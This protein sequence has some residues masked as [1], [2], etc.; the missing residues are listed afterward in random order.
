MPVGFDAATWTCDAAPGSSCGAPSGTGSIDQLV[1][2]GA[3]ST[4]TYIV[5]GTISPAATG[6]LANTATVSPGAGTTD[7]DPTN[8]SATDVDNLTPQANLEIVKTDGAATA[9]P[10]TSV[11]YSIV[12]ANAGPSAAP[13]APIIDT[14]PA[15]LSNASWTC[16]GSNGGRGGAAAGTVGSR[17]GQI[18]RPVRRSPTP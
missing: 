16:T 12:V 5:S 18:C 6:V 2:V 7:T 15:V 14:L 11:T 3:S 13:G 10:G 1:T 4:I 17:R 8:D 9:V